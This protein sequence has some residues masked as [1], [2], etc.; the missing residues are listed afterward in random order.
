MKT[1][2][3]FGLVMASGVASAHIPDAPLAEVGRDGPG[4]LCEPHF[5][6]HVLAGEYVHE[7]VQLEPSYPSSN[8]IKSA[9]GWYVITVLKDAPAR[10]A[11]RARFYTGTPDRI[12]EYSLSDD[13]WQA[14]RFMRV[15][16]RQN[17]PWI[18]VVFFKASN[19]AGQA[20]WR[21]QPLREFRSNEMRDIFRRITFSKPVRADCMSLAVES[22]KP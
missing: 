7:D 3:A 19:P 21:Q 14:R 6:L 10:R 15:P 9:A 17:D 12:Y 16:D 4:N 22:D 13:F 2:W 1:G 18:E 11:R 20:G 8:T 5:T